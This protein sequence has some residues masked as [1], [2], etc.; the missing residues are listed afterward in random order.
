MKPKIFINLIKFYGEIGFL[1]CDND[2]SFDIKRVFYNIGTQ[3]K[4]D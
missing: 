1:E 4:Y 3:K 2:I